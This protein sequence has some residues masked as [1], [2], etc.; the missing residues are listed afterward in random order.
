M[1]FAVEVDY[2][3]PAAKI[4]DMATGWLAGIVRAMPNAV[5]LYANHA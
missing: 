4:S 2:L 3:A 1:S 5:K